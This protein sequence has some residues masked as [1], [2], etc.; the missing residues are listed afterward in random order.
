MSSAVSLHA[1]R[2]LEVDK[3]TLVERDMA[4]A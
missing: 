2:L 4:L 3:G 1:S